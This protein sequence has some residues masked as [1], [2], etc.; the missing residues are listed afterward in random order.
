MDHARDDS[1]LPLLF[2]YCQRGAVIL[3]HNICP[4]CNVVVVVSRSY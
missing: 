1:K 4:A 3:L 2:I